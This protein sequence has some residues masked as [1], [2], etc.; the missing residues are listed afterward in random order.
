MRD[1]H[2][3]VGRRGEPLG[4]GDGIDAPLGAVDAGHDPR[5]GGCGFR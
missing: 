4:K 1:E 2:D 5:T 3:C